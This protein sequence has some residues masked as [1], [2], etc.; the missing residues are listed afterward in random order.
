MAA[1]TENK[2]RKFSPARFFKRIARFFKDMRGETKKI[3]WPTKQQL[4]NSTLV[5][6]VIMLGAG[7]II[8]LLDLGFGELVKLVLGA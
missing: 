1:S 8:W 5:V 2:E 4:W 6:L 7:V 3:V